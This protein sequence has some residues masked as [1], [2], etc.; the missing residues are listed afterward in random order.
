MHSLPLEKRTPMVRAYEVLARRALRVLGGR[1]TP[2][3]FARHLAQQYKL[4]NP[5]GVSKM[6]L[7]DICGH[8]WPLLTEIHAAEMVAR[9]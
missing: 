5:H 8:W 3:G 7:D 9:A 1:I 6:S 4:A 2:L